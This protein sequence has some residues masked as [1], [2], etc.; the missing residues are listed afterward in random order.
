MKVFFQYRILTLTLNKIYI[1]YHLPND[2]RIKIIEIKEKYY[3]QNLKKL[4]KLG[5]TYPNDLIYCVTYD[6]N[7]PTLYRGF[8][9]PEY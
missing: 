6:A 4:I 3:F 5:S 2:C 9:F 7:I 1:K 8:L